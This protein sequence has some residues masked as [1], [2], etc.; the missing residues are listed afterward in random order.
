MAI[1]ASPD[2]DTVDWIERIPFYETRNYVQRVMENLKVY[3][4]APASQAASAAPRRRDAHRPV[5]EP[6][7]HWQ[8]ADRR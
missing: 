4:A 7:R 5:P 3:R 1:R 2:V 8:D 6:P